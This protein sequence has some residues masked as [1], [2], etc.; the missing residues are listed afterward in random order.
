MSNGK[1]MSKGNPYHLPS[2]SPSGGEFTHGP[3]S[4]KAKETERVHKPKKTA[5]DRALARTQKAQARQAKIDA[6][7]KKT[8][9]QMRAETPYRG[10]SS[11]TVKI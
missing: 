11:Y 9:D 4:A 6:A 8:L 7:P 10:L 3:D 5:F 1:S 2:G